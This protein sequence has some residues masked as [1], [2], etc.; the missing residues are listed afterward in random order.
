MELGRAGAPM[1]YRVSI[2]DAGIAEMKRI[3]AALPIA[4][5]LGIAGHPVDAKEIYTWTDENGVV[6]YVD[7]PPNH[8]DAQA[9]DAPE[10][11][12]PGSVSAE[13]PEA[14]PAPRDTAD[15]EPAEAAQPELSAADAKRQELAERRKKR[16]AEQ[17]ERARICDEARRRLAALE[18]SRRV[19]YQDEEGETARMD[20]EE[21]VKLVE[22]SKARIAQYCN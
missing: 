14:A 18:P 19:F 3:L 13:E 16:L 5:W 6:H 15:P 7:T 8:P 2:T 12:R 21:R 9:V 10:A 1:Y 17:Q 20:D 11:Y 4:V 22:E